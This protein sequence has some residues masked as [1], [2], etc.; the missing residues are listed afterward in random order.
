[1]AGDSQPVPQRGEHALARWSA[2]HLR[3]GHR[4]Q[5]NVVLDK[6]HLQSV[7]NVV[8]KLVPVLAVGLGETHDLR[9]GTTKQCHQQKTLSP[10]PFP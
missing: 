9:G 1:M 3:E 2:L 7:L 5:L 4:K 8:L 10:P 6:V